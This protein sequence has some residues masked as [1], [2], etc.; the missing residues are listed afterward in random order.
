MT[1]DE[2]KNELESTENL[3]LIQAEI[4]DLLTDESC[5]RING[6]IT[7]LGEIGKEGVA[8]IKRG[9]IALETQYYP[10]SVNHPNWPQ[11]FV[12]A[13]QRYHTETCYTFK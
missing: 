9:G 6:V 2:F 7:R 4:V 8:Y 12:K 13:G 5:E 1:F 11:P 10:D 3:R